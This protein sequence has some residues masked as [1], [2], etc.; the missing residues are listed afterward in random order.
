MATD[1]PRHRR[2]FR[3]PASVAVVTLLGLAASGVFLAAVSGAVARWAGV[4]LILGLAGRA[5]VAAVIET[6]EAVIVRNPWRTH[7][8]DWTDVVRFEVGDTARYPGTPLARIRGGRAIPLWAA[9]DVGNILRSEHAYA[10]RVV[11]ELNAAVA[12]RGRAK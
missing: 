11:D 8:V 6:P 12:K 2:T 3:N 9:R 4:A 5:A 1:A 7:R 10:L